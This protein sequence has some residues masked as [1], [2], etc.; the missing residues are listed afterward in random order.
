MEFTGSVQAVNAIAAQI[1]L[2]REK[3]SDDTMATSPLFLVIG[4]QPALHLCS[5]RLYHSLNVGL[6]L[7][8]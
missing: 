6:A 2:R 5:A 7:R 4:G 3:N 1:R 8:G